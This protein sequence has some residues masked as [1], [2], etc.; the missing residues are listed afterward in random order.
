MISPLGK[1]SW[2]ADAFENERTPSRRS[3]IKVSRKIDPFTSE[4]SAE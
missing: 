1:R 2:S 4:K 3:Q